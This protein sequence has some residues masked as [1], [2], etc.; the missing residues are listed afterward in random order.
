MNS[1]VISS[2]GIPVPFDNTLFEPMRDSTPLRNEFPKLREELKQHGYF[3]I[4]GFFPVETIRGL[5]E[6]YF[7][8]FPAGFL[9]ES[10]SPHEGI[11]A[12]TQKLAV[13]HGVKGHP[14]YDF[15]R[16]E[17]YHSFVHNPELYAFVSK[18]LEDEVSL[19]KR[20]IVRS[21]TPDCKVASKAHVDFSYLDQGS[22]D[23]LTA[24]IPL[25]DCPPETGALIYL[26][27][28]HNL[29]HRALKMQFGKKPS[30]LWITEDLE[31]MA[32][33]TESKWLYHSYQMGDIVFHS[34]FTVHAT[35]DCRT[36]YM[37][38]S[39]DIRFIRQKEVS[40]PRWL[41]DWR[42]DDGY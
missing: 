20:K 28:S 27:G 33:K 14:A 2:N 39:T 1:K 21:F 15:V 9:K 11:Y 23:V 42:G 6:A 19:L 16:E 32:K 30:S 34:P 22:T 37:R 18:F 36:S 12:G 10:S 8:K 38:L 35:T 29:D 5:R 25:G 3:L 17:K 13:N 31:L 24:W 41:N 7:S 40:D 4:R 26:K